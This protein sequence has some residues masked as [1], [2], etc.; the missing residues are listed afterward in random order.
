MTGTFRLSLVEACTP[1]AHTHRGENSV[2]LELKRWQANTLAEALHDHFSGKFGAPIFEQLEPELPQCKTSSSDQRFPTASRP[3]MMSVYVTSLPALNIWDHYL[4]LGSSDYDKALKAMTVHERDAWRE[5]LDKP[6]SRAI[7]HYKKVTRKRVEAGKVVS[8]RLHHC[9]V[10][11]SKFEANLQSA[12]VKFLQ[13]A[14]AKEIALE[15]AA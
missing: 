14:E 9:I 7:F 15:L 4:L 12:I 13:F 10:P 11:G 8:T 1:M 6:R 2:S 3:A 5:W